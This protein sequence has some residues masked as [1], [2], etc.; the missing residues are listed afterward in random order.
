MMWPTKPFWAPFHLITS[1]SNS[2]NTEKNRD[3]N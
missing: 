1:G 3:E 2:W